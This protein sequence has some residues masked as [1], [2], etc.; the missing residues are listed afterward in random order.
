MQTSFISSLKPYEASLGTICL[1]GILHE[2]KLVP[3]VQLNIPLQS[4]N[5]H[6]L[7]AGAT[8][9]GKTKTIQML[10]EQLASH[11]IPTLL[12]D[13]KGDLSGLAMPGNVNDAIL[14]RQ[15][16]LC[17]DYKPMGFSVELLAM[18]QQPGVKVRE[19]LSEFG[20]LL[21][22]KMLDL[23]ETQT[24]I[25]SILFQYAKDTNLLL[26]DLS[27]IKQLINYA[28]GEGKAT[29]EAK[30]GGLATSSLKSILRYI[31]ELEAQGGDELFGEPSFDVHDLLQIDSQGKGLIS[32]L[33]LMNLQDK[34]KLFSTF[35]LGLLA[36]VYS[37]FPEVGD[38]DKPKLIIFIDEAHLI[39]SHASK[40]L[41]NQLENTVKLI[42]SK[43]VG[44]IFCTQSPDDIP[45]GI[46]S[47]L[48][49]KIQHALRAFTAKDRKA[50]KLVAENFPITSFYD[51]V[52]LLTSL[53]TGKA[54]VSALDTHGQPTP[55]VAAM[56]RAPQSRMGPLTEAELQQLVSQS[57]L[58][59]KYGE[60][61]DRT[62]AKEEL[63]ARQAAQ[64]L[65]TKEPQT[66]SSPK[67]PSTIETL[68][69][70]TL[71][72][73]IVRTIVREITN[74]VMVALGLKKSG[75][76]K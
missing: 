48:G 60:R 73:Q 20:P 43:G 25:I 50:I 15:K 76:K 17:L 52:A 6:G 65:P 75:R 66:T 47:Q 59:K 71:F 12:M 39:F 61:L 24:S 72:R 54:L 34:P 64:P 42:R 38:A 67:D 44:L 4:L 29:I 14:N 23:N 33:R 74:A 57:P 26:L 30:Y 45:E 11:G 68:S 7:I 19:T 21:F 41:L 36:S 63:N 18:G 8:G 2:D 62:S 10:S 27:D 40:A 3:D 5:R 28:Q 58:V 13:I 9:T 22:S 55:L 70:N 32:I 51:I 56:I 1:G 69:K 35:M 37:T 31:I 46:L 49:L 16:M 53:G